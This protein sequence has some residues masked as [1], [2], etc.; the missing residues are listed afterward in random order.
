MHGGC[1][2]RRSAK[3]KDQG[4][5]DRLH[6]RG[7]H[8]LLLISI[9]GLMFFLNLGGATLWDLDE[10]CNSGCAWE[11]MEADNWIV[12]TFNSQLRVDKPALL[13]WLQ[14]FSYLGFGV[15]EFA[16]R[17]PSAL[18]AL[19]TVL[20][21]YELARSMF[22]RTTGLL[23]GVI[24]AS[25]P[26]L[27]GAARFA[28]P[29]SLLNCCTVLTMTVFWLGVARRRWWWFALL[30]LASG[31]AVLAKGPVGLILPGAAITLFLLWER[32]LN[33]VWDRRW[34]VTFWSFVLAA[35]PWYIWV[36]IE[37]KGDFLSGF[38]WKHNIERATSALDNHCGF[39]GYF[40][41]VLFVGTAPWSI[42]L[43]V[44]CWFGFWS[45]IRCP[46]IQ[47]Q[48]WWFRASE[49]GRATIGPDAF[50]RA[51][52]EMSLA[53]KSS[54]YRLLTCWILVY[55]VFFSVARTKLPAY[56][57]PTVV[58]CTLLIARFLQRWRIESIRLPD[59]LVH[60]SLVSLSL[61][62][63][64][65]SLALAIAGGVGELPILRGHYFPGLE[66]WA[67]VGLIPIAAA[68]A[69]SWFARARQYGRFITAV[70]VC[71]ISLLGPMAAFGSVLFNQCKAPRRLVEQSDALRPAE[72]IRIGCWHVEHLPSLNFYLKR[73]VEHFYDEKALANFLMSR[74]PVYLFIPLEDWRRIEIRL[75]ASTRIIGR[76]HDMYH[77]TEVVVV[78]NR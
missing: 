65:F 28:N 54:A 3:Y 25:T 10:G 19:A 18:A 11:M 22:K 46:W 55:M 76:Q 61:I 26:M 62:G 77:H 5:I 78:T 31:L 33:L 69:C 68:A 63:L 14:I 42:F 37:T 23:A 52:G 67:L 51:R 45:S 24:V 32:Q 40:L 4:M 21:A 64:L 66:T 41:A 70:A 75:A 29:D 8:Y 74:L 1:M 13:Y 50:G 53:D 17:F 58:P 60:G 73:N 35:F 44:A 43:V 48:K 9:S 27:C 57:L 38:L 15:N 20:L 49:V 16:A 30:G 12:P 7:W 59:W 39:P 2:P 34:F 56:I 47:A 6:H 72:D 71:A 36:G